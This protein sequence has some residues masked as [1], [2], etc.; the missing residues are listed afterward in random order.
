MMHMAQVL[1]DNNFGDTRTSDGLAGPMAL[2]LIVVLSVATV[3]LVRNMNSRLKR[4]PD[5]FESASMGDG[6]QSDQKT[7]ATD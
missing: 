3:F 4:L 6:T 5:T 7:A 1:A 2:L